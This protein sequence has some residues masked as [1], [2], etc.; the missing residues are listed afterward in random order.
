MPN[1]Q[2]ISIRQRQL[3]TEV[4]KEPYDPPAIH[5]RL[6]DRLFV[7]GSKLKSIYSNVQME[8]NSQQTIW[9]FPELKMHIITSLPAKPRLVCHKPQTYNKALLL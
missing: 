9:N 1:L 6:Q 8:G 2:E 7:D 3:S 5:P 4:G